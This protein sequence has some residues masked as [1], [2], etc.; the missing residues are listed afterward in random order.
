MK[1]RADVR[2]EIAFLAPFGK[3]GVDRGNGCIE[4]FVNDSRTI[5]LI[6]SARAR[7]AHQGCHY[8]PDAGGSSKPKHPFIEKGLAPAFYGSRSGNDNGR[9]VKQN[10]SWPL[11]LPKAFLLGPRKMIGIHAAEPFRTRE[12]ARV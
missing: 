4:P 12:W 1:G 8:Q 2:P 10:F 6:L 7:D 3:H 11:F 9:A 5:L